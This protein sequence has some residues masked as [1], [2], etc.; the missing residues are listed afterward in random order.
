MTR[1]A[2]YHH[3]K[4]KKDLFLAVLEQIQIDTGKYIEEKASLS[5]DLWEQLILG[6]IAFIEFATLSENSRILL[7]DAPNIIGWTEWKKSDENNSEFYL[8]EHLSLLKQEGILI[9]I[10]INLV[11]HIISGALNE[12]SLYI[13]K[14]SPINKKDLYT[15]IS[16]LLKDFKFES[17]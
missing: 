8:K 12:L 5:N 16:K 11:T 17:N 2:V 6:C 13:A 15:A 4:N 10:D 9:D 1:G 3:F 7:I 14:T